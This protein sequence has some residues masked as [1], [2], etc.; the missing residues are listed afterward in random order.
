MDSNKK[1]LMTVTLMLLILAAA[2]IINIAFNFRA[3]AYESAKDKASMMAEIV[4]D[5]LTAHM[6]NGTMEHRHSFLSSVAQAPSVNELWIIRA[7]SVI[8]Q[9]GEGYANEKPRDEIDKEVLE[10][11]KAIT[12]ID[13]S[14]KRATLRATIPYISTAYENTNC[15]SCHNAQE[16][17]VLGAISMSFD[18]DEAR[19]VGFVTILKIF[20]INLLFIIVALYII[21]RYTKPYIQMFDQTKTAL[22]KAHKGDFT[23]RI[24]HNVPKEAIPV[25]QSFNKLFDSMDK[26][27]GEIKSS[28]STFISHHN[29]DNPLSEATTIIQELSDVYRFKRTIELDKEKGQIYSRIVH[30]L[31]TKFEILHF[32]FFEVSHTKNQRELIYI[33]HEKSFCSQLSLNNAQE[34]RTF[35]T[36]SD[37]YSSDFPNLCDQCECEKINYICVP[38][39]I[40]DNS[41]L[42]LSFSTY[43]ATE[44]QRIVKL[45]PTIKQYLETAKPVLESK[46]LMEILK[47]SSLKD[48]QTGL[49]N[50]RFLDEFV[51]KISAQSN[52][53]EQIYGI[54]MVDIDYFKM[55]NDSY[56]HDVGDIVIKQLADVLTNEIR[57]SDLAIRFGGEEF[58][59]L[60][61]NPSSEGAIKVA[62]NIRKKFAQVSIKLDT[63]MISKTVS[64]GVSLFPEDADSIWKVIK[65]ADNALYQAK[66]NGRDQV[67]RF[68]PAEFEGEDF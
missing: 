17:E 36:K 31:K 58:L 40:N 19:S 44:Y 53:Q 62:Q 63:E 41:S 7:P 8:K 26:T 15:M 65:F 48:A 47:D 20:G 34:C 35:R 49:Y 4:R 42:V 18:I 66:D 9:F 23:A 55:V 64:I 39:Q 5:G 37:I 54:L 24:E 22:K 11:G 6:I 67:V 27:F 28:L 38:Y 25:T 68:N 29:D 57:E 1:V 3:Y 43:D 61:H 56:G 16:K 46:V 21:N 51:D 59:V 30:L 12:K 60:L 14:A 33:T 2:T 45:I 50:R 10:Q 13:E 52:R 32:A